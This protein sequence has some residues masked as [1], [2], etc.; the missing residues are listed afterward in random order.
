MRKKA[1]IVGSYLRGMQV[2]PFSV[3]T[4]ENPSTC[5]D[6]ELVGSTVT[7]LWVCRM[8]VLSGAKR[9][10]LEPQGVRIC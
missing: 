10:L 4:V 6:L 2:C 1:F 8:N 7:F 5:S 9:R 3:A